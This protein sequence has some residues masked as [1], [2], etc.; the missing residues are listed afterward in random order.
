MRTPE[1]RLR[2]AMLLPEGFTVEV[3]ASSSEVDL[4]LMV[5]PGT[6]YDSRFTAWCINEHEL[7]DVNGWLFIVEEVSDVEPAA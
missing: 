1:E 2:L 3:F 7:L 4:E 5:Q 6:D